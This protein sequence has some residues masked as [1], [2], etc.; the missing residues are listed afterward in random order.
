[1]TGYPPAEDSLDRMHRAG[2]SVG[3]YGT[4]TLWIVSGRNGENLLYAEG[5]TRAEAWWRACEQ[6]ASVGMLSPPAD[7]VGR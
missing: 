2:W 7:V 1:V 4:A 5:G 3:D 6:A